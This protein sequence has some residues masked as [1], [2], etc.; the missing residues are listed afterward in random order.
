MSIRARFKIDRR[1]FRLNLDLSIPGKGV[2]ALFGPSGCG[3]TTLLRAIAGL[4]HAP[5]GYL[6]V[7]DHV[8]QEQGKFLPP[9]KRPIGYVFQ[10]A[11]L[12]AHLNVQRNLEFGRNRV[13]DAGPGVSL[14]HVCELLEIGHLL[15][16]KPHQLSG[17]EQQRV[18]IA[19]ALAVNPEMLLLDEPLAALD[20]R[21]KREILP[22]L[23]ALN[24]ELD[25]PVLYVSH[26]RSEVVR[27]ADHMVMLEEGEV[28]AT[29]PVDELFSRLDLALAHEPDTKSVVEAVV[30]EH[31]ELYRLT[32]L[33]FPGGRFAVEHRPLPQGSPVRLQV[34]AR[35]VSLAL[36]CED[37]SSILNTFPAVVEQVVE[38]G[39][40]QVTVRLT[41]GTVPLLSRI[42]RKS[43]VELGLEPG[44]RV[45]A[46]AKSVALTA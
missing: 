46:Q 30:A 33:D 23:E 43:A 4:E 9:H 3:K 13:A 17:G 19:R 12:F 18:A 10:E 15:Q 8:W 44:A 45:F 42:T 28:R 16:R 41:L 26:S 11:S 34:F 5:D 7:G 1:A 35:D 14:Q 40:S 6:R 27:L 22:Y 32:Y 24:R 36:S 2:T 39:P 37:R 20:Q 38:E 21:R 25:I 31:D 29:G